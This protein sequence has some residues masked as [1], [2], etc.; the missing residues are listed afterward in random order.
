MPL[1]ITAFV[2]SG[3]HRLMKKESR[4]G[5]VC[6]YRVGIRPPD[7]FQKIK[8]V[9]VFKLEVQNFAF[10]L[11]IKQGWN[12]VNHESVQLALYLEWDIALCNQS[13]LLLFLQL[14]LL[15]LGFQK[16]STRSPIW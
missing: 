7:R 4:E 2:A 1:K 3:S 13:T 16:K 11:N 12:T 9:P 15:A 14:G 5:F 6:S 10:V 8:V